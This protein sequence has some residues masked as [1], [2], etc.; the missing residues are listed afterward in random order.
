MERHKD[1]MELTCSWCGEKGTYTEVASLD[2]SGG[3]Y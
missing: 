2:V 3:G 1:Y